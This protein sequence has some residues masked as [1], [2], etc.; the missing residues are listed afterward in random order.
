MSKNRKAWLIYLDNETKEMLRYKA[1]KE[2][3]S[4]NKIVEEILKVSLGKELGCDLFYK[5]LS[6]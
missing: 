2:N 1:Y 5:K 6:K 3:T 4:Q